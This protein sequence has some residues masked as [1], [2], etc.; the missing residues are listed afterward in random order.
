MSSFITPGATNP[1][2][3]QE[4]YILVLDE[5]VARDSVP[6]QLR[7]ADLEALDNMMRQWD[8]SKENTGSPNNSRTHQGTD[9]VQREIPSQVLPEEEDA[10]STVNGPKQL[11]GGLS[12]GLSIGQIFDAAQIMDVQQDMLDPGIGFGLAGSWLWENEE[13][14]G[15]SGSSST[16][17]H[18]D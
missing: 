15:I 10:G 11:H 14:F 12:D 6:A 18:G 3:L 13:V 4:E 16:G 7:R 17:S 8:A 2:P 5:L 9:L 1:S